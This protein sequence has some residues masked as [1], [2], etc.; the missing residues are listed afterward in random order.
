MLKS[1]KIFQV[2]SVL[3]FKNPFLHKLFK[4]TV[5]CRNPNVWISDSAK[6]RTI[7]RSN[8]VLFGFRTATSLDHFL[9]KIK[10]LMTIF[11]RK[12]T[13]LSFLSEIRTFERSCVRLSDVIFHP[14]TE[15]SVRFSA[16]F[17]VQTKFGTKQKG[18]VRNPNV[19][20]FRHSTVTYC[21][22]GG[23]R[24]RCYFWDARDNLVGCLTPS[25]FFL[26]LP[27]YV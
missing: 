20:G 12:T 26:S 15:R 22:P 9:Y 16:L 4:Y 25:Y 2:L 6:I 19:F 3:G 24:S 14:K 21:G 27:K 1:L 8:K 5:E 18:P 10:I 17:C 11:I 23:K 7:D 13:Q